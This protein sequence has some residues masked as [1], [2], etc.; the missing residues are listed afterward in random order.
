MYTIK[1]TQCLLFLLL[2][3]T[4]HR[5]IRLKE[6]TRLVKNIKQKVGINMSLASFSYCHLT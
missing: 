6:D 5:E 3:I 1:Q 4:K 2:Q